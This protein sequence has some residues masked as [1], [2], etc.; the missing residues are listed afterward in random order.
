[1]RAELSSRLHRAEDAEQRALAQ[2]AALEAGLNSTGAQVEALT[3]ELEVTQGL[4][5][6]AEGSRSP[7]PNPNPKSQ[8]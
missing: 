4:V 6:R 3:A 8:I 1:M 7:K 5:K 2:L